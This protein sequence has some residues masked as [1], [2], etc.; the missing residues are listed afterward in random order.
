MWVSVLTT[1][2]SL[3]LIN[4]YSYNTNYMGRIYGQAIP[5]FIIGTVISA[6]LL[7]KDECYIKFDY[8]KYTIP[9]TLPI[10]FHVISNLILGQSDRIM[11]KEMCDNAA[12]G[13]YTLAATFSAVVQSLWNAFNTSWVAFYYEYSSKEEIERIRLSTFNYLEFFSVIVCGFIL[14]SPEVFIIFA[15]KE[16]QIGIR[17]IPIFTLGYL[18]V[19][20][21][22][23]PVNYEFFNKQ[24]RIIAIITMLTALIN[25][26]LNYLLIRCYH[27]YGAVLATTIAHGIQF[28]LHYCAAKKIKKSYFPYKIYY[29]IPPIIIV[30]F[31]IILFYLNINWVI[32][33]VIALAIGLFEIRRIYIR[34]SIY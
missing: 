6:K 19:F 13:I 28:A 4:L 12:V 18:F 26:A 17:F 24:T 27:I 30:I 31:C 20:L 10:V 11:L 21:Y 29:F 5:Y 32:R 3:V 1:F 33:W 16:F 2:L 8:W 25:V 9:I 23:F 34:K 7:R 22:S 15:P 14:L